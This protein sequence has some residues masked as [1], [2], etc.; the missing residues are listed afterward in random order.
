VAV[1]NHSQPDNRSGEARELVFERA[2][3]SPAVKTSNALHE[4]GKA[5][6]NLDDRRILPQ[7]FGVQVGQNQARL[8][9][10][11]QANIDK[12]SCRRVDNT[13]RLNSKQDAALLS[14]P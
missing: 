7:S 14:F 5:V 4:S 2:D 11:R 10:P 6:L 9:S 8:R 3:F 12:L 1:S 13:A